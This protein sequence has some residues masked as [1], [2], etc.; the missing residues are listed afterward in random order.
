[1]THDCT[2]HAPGTYACYS[3]HR[4]PCGPCRTIGRRYRK[5]AEY[6][7]SIGASHYTPAGPVAD[8]VG[9]L[10][11]AGM[12]RAEV[13]RLARVEPVAITRL[14]RGEYTRIRRDRAARLLSINPPPVAEQR[15][16]RVPS[17]GVVRRLDA[18]ALLGWSVATVAAMA[19]YRAPTFTNARTI[20]TVYASTRA[21]VAA[22]YDRLWD[23]PAPF[24][25]ATART[26][27]MAIRRGA[28]P[29][30]AW[31][32]GAGPHGID[33]P[34]ATPDGIRVRNVRPYGVDI[35]AEI[36]H[37]L[38]AGESAEAIAAAVGV[39]RDSLLDRLRR[40]GH[41]DVAARLYR[42]AA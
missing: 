18:L 28:Q 11:D 17:C 7:A 29:A 6:R 9:R 36:E 24:D 32:D 23:T 27:A 25:E 34:D 3:K 5:S 8:H 12:G 31:D 13:S 33:N 4:C 42:K 19:G 10:L 15:S 40:D 22:V 21:A 26:R 41:R 1:M 37:L 39:A 30:L 2:T 16:G 38:D 35:V 20:P 14:M